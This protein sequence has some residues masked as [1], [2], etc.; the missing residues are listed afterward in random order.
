[1]LKNGLEVA[2]EAINISFAR[3]YDNP[4]LAVIYEYMKRPQ[5]PSSVIYVQYTLLVACNLLGDSFKPGKNLQKLPQIIDDKNTH[6]MDGQVLDSCI[7]TPPLEVYIFIVV[8]KVLFSY[9]LF[10]CFL[11]LKL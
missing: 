9:F 10:V 11:N 4:P 1:M 7:R 5:F 8:Y 2:C 6:I 3:Q